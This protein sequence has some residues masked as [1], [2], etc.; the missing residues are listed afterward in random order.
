MRQWADQ[1]LV[2]FT[3]Q[4]CAHRAPQCANWYKEKVQACAR[5]HLSNSKN[6]SRDNVKSCPSANDLFTAAVWAEKRELA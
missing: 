2:V 4:Y 3:C 6:Y 1:P 5:N